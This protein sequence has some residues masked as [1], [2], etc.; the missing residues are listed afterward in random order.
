MPKIMPKALQIQ[1]LK[2][3][4]KKKGVDPDTVDLEHLVDSKLTYSE[5]KKNVMKILGLSGRKTLT[6]KIQ[7]LKQQLE[8]IFRQT[9]QIETELRSDRARMVDERRKAKVPK[10]P[11]TWFKHPDKYD[12]PGVDMPNTTVN[13]FIKTYLPKKKTGKRRKGNSKA[14]SKQK[15]GSKRGGRKK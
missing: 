8:D 9:V 3:F 15:A 11:D 2:Q 12:L 14:K 13:D 6:S 10:K 1:K 4:L 5:N 7:A